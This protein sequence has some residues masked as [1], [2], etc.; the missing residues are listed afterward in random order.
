M[1]LS[2]AALDWAAVKPL[3]TQVRRTSSLA[4]SR[5]SATVICLGAAFRTASV[6]NSGR[7]STRM[8]LQSAYSS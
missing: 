2:P 5:P 8:R 4:V 3:R 1:I 7:L 6:M